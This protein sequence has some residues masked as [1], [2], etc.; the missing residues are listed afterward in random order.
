MRVR[1]RKF[2][3]RQVLTDTSL[4]RK[5][6][7]ITLAFEMLAL[8]DMVA[9]GIKCI[10]LSWGLF[11]LIHNFFITPRAFKVKY[12]Y[13]LWSF[14]ALMVVTSFVHMSLWFVPNLAIAYHT[15]ICFF[16]FYGM[17]TEMSHE[18]I[19]REMVFLF[20]FFVMFGAAFGAVSLL[21]LFINTQMNAAWYHL[22][23]YGSRLI[24]VYTNSNI[25][26]FSMIASVVA[27]DVLNDS[28]IRLKFKSI[29]VNKWLLLLCVIINLVCLFLSD[30][31]AAILF[32]IIYCTLRVFCISFFKSQISSRFKFITSGL[33]LVVFCFVMLSVSLA[34]RNKCQDFMSIIVN[35]IHKVE[36]VKKDILIDELEDESQNILPDEPIPAVSEYVPD[37]HIGRANY[38]ISSGRNILWNQGLQLFWKNPVL[39]IGRANL[40][41]YGKKYL[42]KRLIY[43][44]LHNAYLTILVSNGVLGFAVFMIFSFAVAGD[45][46]RHL[47]KCVNYNYFGIFFKFFA[48]LVAYC[49]YCFVEKAIIYDM[50]FMVSFFWLIL[51]YNISY[52]RCFSKASAKIL[53]NAPKNLH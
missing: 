31:N 37:L 26:A 3:L 7:M 53:N 13:L 46:C 8:L 23:I 40:M 4:F 32:F 2:N 39:G 45:V 52:I 16:V 25:L 9:L 35:D 21:I 41:M 30:S 28:Y 51:G 34:V 43:S 11:L 14:I 47:F 17:Y 20:R 18:Q 49:G 6:Y 29:R 44:D 5:I 24:G 1:P 19:E 22:G 38:E 10:V 36:E 50:T 15:A 42:E 33:L 12:K 27:C 48:V